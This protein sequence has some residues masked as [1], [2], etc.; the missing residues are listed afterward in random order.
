MPVR[1]RLMPVRAILGSLIL[2]LVL[3]IPLPGAAQAEGTAG[4]AP[5]IWE[6]FRSAAEW[7]VRKLGRRPTRYEVVSE[8]D[9]RV[10]RAVSNDAASIFWRRVEAEEAGA[11]GESLRTVS[12]RWR[13]RSGLWENDRERE[14]A[15]DDYAARLFVAFG[16]DPFR[17]GQPALCY[18][19]AARE[20]VESVYRNPYVRS[21]AMVVVRSGPEGAG[22]WTTE[23]RDFVADYRRIF[24][25][26][27]P[28][29]S[30]IGLMVDTDDTDSRATAW[31]AEIGLA[32]PP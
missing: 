8:G 14:K 29:L 7:R 24:G 16:D 13:V 18:V 2:L 22:E 9:E 12:W 5:M 27:S 15:G 28:R 3:L 19:W 32:P 10:L 21:V 31:F 23:S 4:S 11:A 17:A 1:A 6:D 20:P 25:Q 30:A 26:P